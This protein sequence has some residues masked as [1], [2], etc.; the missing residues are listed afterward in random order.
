[1]IPVLAGQR[2]RKDKYNLQTESVQRVHTKLVHTPIETTPRRLD[3]C[4]DVGTPRTDT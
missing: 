2:G 4:R 3:G 1:M